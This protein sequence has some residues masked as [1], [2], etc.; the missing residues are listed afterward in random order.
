MRLVSVALGIW[1][2]I[3]ESEPT[4]TQARTAAIWVLSDPGRPPRFLFDQPDDRTTLERPIVDEQLLEHCRTLLSGIDRD[5][6]YLD[7]FRIPAGTTADGLSQL[8]RGFAELAAPDGSVPVRLLR[9]HKSRWGIIYNAAQFAELFLPEDFPLADDYVVNVGLQGE[10]TASDLEFEPGDVLWCHV[11]SI[12]SDRITL[13]ARGWDALE[14]FVRSTGGAGLHDS[15]PLLERAG[16]EVPAAGDHEAWQNLGYVGPM[17]IWE[18]AIEQGAQKLLTKPVRFGRY[19]THDLVALTIPWGDD[20][21]SISNEMPRRRIG[22]LHAVAIGP[23]IIISRF[24]RSE[25]H[26]GRFTALELVDRLKMR[27][28]SGANQIN[29]TDSAA[30]RALGRANR[31]CLDHLARLVHT[32]EEELIR[33]QG[34]MAPWIVRESDEPPTRRMSQLAVSVF[35]NSRLLGDLA[36]WARGSSWDSE[37]SEW[38]EAQAAEIAELRQ[39]VQG[40]QDRSLATLQAIA[41]FDTSRIAEAEAER[42]QRERARDRE[43]AERTERVNTLISIFAAAI[44]VPA[45]VL[46]IFSASTWVPGQGAKAGFAAMLGVAAIAG[47]VTYVV[48]SRHGLGPSQ[49]TSADDRSSRKAADQAAPPVD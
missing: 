4:G 14:G 33:F 3:A 38:S 12:D 25:R 22:E 9:E 43:E 47:L 20:S 24:G 32:A 5:R 18:A 34:T 23:R 37:P 13:D 21:K 17:A 48:L 15:P 1:S 7:G 26:W 39:Q 28:S 29:P 19:P 41:S 2:E 35:S 44:A 40:L 30:G 8:S 27:R 6:V 36:R 49:R 11:D 45:V 46:A 42:R 31:A 16:E 10:K